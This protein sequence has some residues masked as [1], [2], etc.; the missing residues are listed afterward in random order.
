MSFVGSFLIFRIPFAFLVRWI[1]RVL[2]WVF[3]GPW[4]KLVD[5][6]YFAGDDT[7]DASDDDRIAKIRE[8]MRKQ[9]ENFLKKASNYQQK[10]ER[11]LK[12]KSIKN[13]MV[14]YCFGPIIPGSGCSYV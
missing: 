5:R 12:Q 4:M 14:G 10:R 9:Y 2:A 8:G 6:W 11:A 13:F 1:L 7:N 3:L